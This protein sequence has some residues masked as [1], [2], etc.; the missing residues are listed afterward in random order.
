LGGSVNESGLKNRFILITYIGTKGAMTAPFVGGCSTFG[1]VATLALCSE[2]EVFV[3][4]VDAKT[5][6]FGVTAVAEAQIESR[7][8]QRQRQ[9]L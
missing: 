8:L 9:L 4:K 1:V 5:L 7:Q 2:G 3:F 6:P